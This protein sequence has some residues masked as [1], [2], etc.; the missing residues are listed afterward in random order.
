[1]LKA[2]SALAPSWTVTRDSSP[3]PCTA[4]ATL[5][6]KWEYVCTSYVLSDVTLA[7]GSGLKLC[8]MAITCLASC[9][10]FSSV[11]ND[12]RQ[13]VYVS[14]AIHVL[15]LL[16]RKC[17]HTGLKWTYGDSIDRGARL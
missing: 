12:V 2:S 7:D 17:T 13:S 6:V 3:S 16:N 15:S 14:W 11:G 8:T 9:P 10:L 5:T 4:S 1:M